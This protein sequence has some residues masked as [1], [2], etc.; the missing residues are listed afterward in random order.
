LSLS[1]AVSLFAAILA[2]IVYPFA[3]KT[4]QGYPTPGETV[5]VSLDVFT[6]V[7]IVCILILL[8]RYRRASDA[9]FAGMIKDNLSTIIPAL[10]LNLIHAFYGLIA[11]LI[12]PAIAAIAGG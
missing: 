10:L 2:A 3:H 4:E 7:A 9:D 12:E 11:T 6:L 1:T 8:Y 5:S